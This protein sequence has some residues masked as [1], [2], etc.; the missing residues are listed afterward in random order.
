MKEG[1]KAR[2]LVGGQNSYKFSQGDV[3]QRNKG[4]KSLMVVEKK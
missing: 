4:H 2:E 3:L 1:S